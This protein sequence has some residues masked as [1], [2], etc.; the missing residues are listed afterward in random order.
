MSKVHFKK[1]AKQFIGKFWVRLIPSEAVKFC[2]DPKVPK[3]P[4]LSSS[5]PANFSYR[6]TIQTLGPLQTIAL[7]PNLAAK[8]DLNYLNLVQFFGS[9]E[10]FQ[11]FDES[12][13]S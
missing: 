10:I 6:D 9:T 11:K 5:K 8:S 2:T 13:I 3:M 1:V 7:G 12:R 4:I